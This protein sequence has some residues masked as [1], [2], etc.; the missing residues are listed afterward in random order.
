MLKAV[1]TNFK[2]MFVEHYTSTIAPYH[3][4][5]NERFMERYTS[6]YS[7]HQFIRNSY[8]DT[9]NFQDMIEAHKEEWDQFIAR[10]THFNSWSEMLNKAEEQ[11]VLERP[12]GPYLFM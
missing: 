5:F 11:Y 12:H 1:F 3:L 6:F 2:K 9:T 8:L 7:W 4:L 10:T